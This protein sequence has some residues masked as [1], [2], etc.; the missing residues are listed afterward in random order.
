MLTRKEPIFQTI[1]SLLVLDLY[2]Y[3][4]YTNLTLENSG[5]IF[6]GLKTIA[7]VTNLMVNLALRADIQFAYPRGLS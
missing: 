5:R 4:P 3:Q 1:C 7:L 2:D 6:P